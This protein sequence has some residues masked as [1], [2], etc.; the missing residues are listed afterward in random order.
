MKTDRTENVKFIATTNF[1]DRLHHILQLLIEICFL[2]D[3][4]LFLRLLVADLSMCL[5]AGKDIAQKK[6]C[7]SNRK[8]PC[9]ANK[10]LLKVSRRNPKTRG[11]IC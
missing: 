1:K 8:I 6:S 5:F 4:L 2:L 3:Y 9:P 11:E 7:C 10:C